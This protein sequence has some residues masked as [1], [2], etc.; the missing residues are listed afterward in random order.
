[1]IE[2]DRVYPLGTDEQKAA[3]QERN[4][5][6]KAAAKNAYDRARTAPK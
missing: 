4:Q 5:L 6:L 1:L 3:N 2:I